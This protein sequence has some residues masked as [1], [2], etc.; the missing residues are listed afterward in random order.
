MTGIVKMGRDTLQA[1]FCEMQQKHAHPTFATLQMLVLQCIISLG[2]ALKIRVSAVRF[3]PRPPFTNARLLSVGRFHLGFSQYNS[4][5][6]TSHW[7]LRGPDFEPGCL[8][9]AHAPQVGFGVLYTVMMWGFT[10]RAACR[11]THTWPRCASARPASC[12]A[13]CSGCGLGQSGGAMR[14]CRAP[15]WPKR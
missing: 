5:P 13:K 6:S 2:T 1:A 10:R 12:P 9:Q 3:C 4:M 8:P 11:P 7:Q 15:S 14:E